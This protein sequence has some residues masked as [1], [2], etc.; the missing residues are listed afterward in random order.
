MDIEWRRQLR[1]DLR[2]GVKG[3]EWDEL[4]A[5]IVAE[6]PN[7]DRVR[8]VMPELSASQR[9]LLDT[10]VQVLERRGLRVDPG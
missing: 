8:F 6:L 5:A 3:E 4:L 9:Q 10:L 2:P 7:I 1:V